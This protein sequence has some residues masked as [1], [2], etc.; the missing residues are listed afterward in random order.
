MEE[1]D[2]L[3]HDLRNEKTIRYSKL[4]ALLASNADQPAAEAVRQLM[5][6]EKVQ[7]EIGDSIAALEDA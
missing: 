7:S 1:L 4:E 3:L 6:L 5:F 2:R